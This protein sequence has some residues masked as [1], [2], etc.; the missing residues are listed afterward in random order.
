M[1][2]ENA[3]WI[4]YLSLVENINYYFA[5]FRFIPP[6]TVHI[7]QRRK[8]R[9]I[10]KCRTQ[11]RI[12]ETRNSECQRQCVF[13]YVIHRKEITYNLRNF[14]IFRISENPRKYKLNFAHFVATRIELKT[15]MSVVQIKDT[16]QYEKLIA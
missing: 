12:F 5:R 16:A 2:V 15:K 10:R 3:S 6:L 4:K 8:H 1:R 11:S 7:C 13:Q 9:Q 14:L